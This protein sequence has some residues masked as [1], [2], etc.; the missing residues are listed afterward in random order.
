MD[1]EEIFDDLVRL[2]TRWWNTLDARL[3][4]AGAASLGTYN[5]LRVVDT[6][7]NCRVQDVAASLE[8]TVGGAS[9][10]VDRVQRHGFCTR[11]PN[12]DDRR[13]SVLELTDIG[14]D[15]LS[16]S[17]SV[18]DQGLRRFFAVLDEDRVEEFGRVLADLRSAPTEL[19]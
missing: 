8:I 3:K 10:A 2:E 9:Q 5:V 7:R 19:E 17:R 14:R 4:R 6:T 16:R 12:P 1:A 18:V 13:S 11:V 15:T